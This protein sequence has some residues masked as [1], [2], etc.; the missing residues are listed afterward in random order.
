[1]LDRETAI[2]HDRDVNLF[3][4]RVALVTGA[5][6]E[7]GIGFAAAAILGSRGARVAIAATTERIQSRRAEL[8]QMGVEAAGFEADL[9]DSEQAAGLIAGVVER[10]GRLDILVNNAGMVQTGVEE[11]SPRFADT[12]PAGW[13]Q[14]IA[15]NLTTAVNVTRAAV[16]VMVAAGYGRIVNVSSVTGPM[17]SSPE[18]S[19]YSAAKA[20]IDGL[21]RAL[22]IEIGRD[23]VT[24]NSVAPGW[25]DTGSSLD[26][27]RLAGHHTPV[28]RP[29]TPAEVAEL[30][31]FLASEGAS[32]IT[33]QSMVVDGGNIIQEY[34]G[35][36]AGWY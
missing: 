2:G 33:G 19:G 7:S 8:E 9:T 25:I 30:I 28:G 26:T 27:E 18:S 6:S 36:P 35:P 22:A 20:G 10:F 12:T 17:V 13:D 16:P 1:V 31:A 3:E 21:T 29:G 32:Y 23:G 24:V 4:A 15:L 34:K 11:S 14:T 5:G